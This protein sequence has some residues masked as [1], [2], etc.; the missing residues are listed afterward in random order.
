MF[1]LR[2]SLLLGPLVT[3]GSAVRVEVEVDR[4]LRSPSGPGGGEHRG[5]VGLWV[6]VKTLR[7]VKGPRESRN[8]LEP[9]LSLWP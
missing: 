1:A 4:L 6:G 8:G 5:G 7:A 2:D 9:P 3:S